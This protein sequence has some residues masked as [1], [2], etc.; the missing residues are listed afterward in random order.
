MPR[1]Q[2]PPRRSNSRP[3]SHSR[4]AR[5]R[6]A[7]EL[8]IAIDLAGALIKDDRLPEARAVLA[9][10]LSAFPD[11]GRSTYWHVGQSMTW[12]VAQPMSEVE[13]AEATATAERAEVTGTLRVNAPVSFGVRE[14]APLLSGFAQLHPALTLD[15]GL[16][17]RVVDVVEEGWDLVIRI[18]RIEDRSMIARK[19]ASCRCLVAGAPAYLAERGT[20]SAISELA[21]HN[22]L[23]YTL[24][25][26]L[27][28]AAG[29]SAKPAASS[30]RSREIC[31]R[32][33][34]THFSRRR[35]QA[36][37]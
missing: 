1:L 18:G 24:S 4:D 5:A 21:A 15:L 25:R 26:T 20:P 19:L 17:D 12:H 34:E 13:E 10:V 22:C 8:K 30:F 31:R 33:T 36:K 23:G 9:P 11:G 37:G 2:S 35:W 3:L 29:C 28:Q 32:I 6:P 7:W 14:I 27:G 16:S